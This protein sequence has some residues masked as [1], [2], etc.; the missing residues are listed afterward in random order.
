MSDGGNHSGRSPQVSKW[1]EV[2]CAVTVAYVGLIG[3][4]AAL[5]AT[6]SLRASG[7][8]HASMLAKVLRAPLAWFD[9]T[10]SGRLLNRFSSDLAAVDTEVMDE[11]STMVDNTC[12]VAAIVLVIVGTFPPMCAVLLPVVAVSGGVGWVYQRT[13]QELKRLDST[14]RSPIYQAFG[15]ALG[16]LDT[17][18]A[19]GH[20]DLM[21]RRFGQAVDDHTRAEFYLWISNRWLVI[22][23]QALSSAVAASL[24]AYV[25]YFDGGRAGGGGEERQLMAGIVLVRGLF[26]FF[27]LSFFV[28]NNSEKS[29]LATAADP[30]LRL[31]RALA[32]LTAASPPFACCRP[33]G[34]AAPLFSDA[35][36]CTRH[37]TCRL[38]GKP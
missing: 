9:A 12:S 30:P 27:F 5:S 37:S 28:E 24:G 34:L 13:S 33:R 38:C 4:R 14:T 19:M 23:L 16:G 10:P 29:S 2:Y 22:R 20:G 17:L 26:S 25:L 21:R 8:V 6:G 1:T 35:H 31:A 3:I 36:R 18:R 7:L 32:A 15:E 11:L